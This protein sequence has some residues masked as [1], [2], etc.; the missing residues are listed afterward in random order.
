MTTMTLMKVMIFSHPLLHQN[1]S[2]KLWQVLHVTLLGKTGRLQGPVVRT[3]FSLNGGYK[4]KIET[5]F[6][7]S[8]NNQ[9]KSFEP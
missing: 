9:T 1:H 4:L 7:D 8:F 3:P 5:K 2:G 6:I